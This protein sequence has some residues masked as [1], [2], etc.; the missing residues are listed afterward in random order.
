MA[1]QLQPLAALELLR[2]QARVALDR[3]DE[4][5]GHLPGAAA[6]PG[7]D[8]ARLQALLSLRASLRDLVTELEAQL[9]AAD[10]ARRRN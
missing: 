10:P 6:E 8:G 9:E 7:P 1:E 5:I 4:R 3:L 2:R